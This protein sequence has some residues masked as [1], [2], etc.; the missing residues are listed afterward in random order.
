MLLSLHIKNFVLI[1]DL[2]IDFSPQLNIIT[3]E[4]GAGKSILLGALNLILG[5]RADT[6]VLKDNGKTCVIEGRFSLVNYDLKEIFFEEDIDYLEQSTIRREIRASGKSRVFVNDNQITLAGLKKIAY[7]IIDIHEQFD[8]HFLTKKDFQFDVIDSLAQ[9]KEEVNQ[10]R[11]RFQQLKEKENQLKAMKAKAIEEAQKKDFLEF[12]LNEIESLK[13]K[14]GEFKTLE[15]ELSFTKN[16]ELID[17]IVQQ[18]EHIF[19]TADESILDQMRSLLIKT[20]SASGVFEP[21]QQL[22]S[23]LESSLIEL[24]DIQSEYSSLKDELEIEPGRSEIIETRMGEIFRVMKK[25]YL[26]QSDDI[27][28]LAQRL[29]DELAEISQ[30]DAGI[31]KYQLEIEKDR[32]ELEKM[33]TTISKRRQSQKNKI[34]KSVLEKLIHLQ[35]DKSRFEIS[36]ETMDHLDEYGKDKIS[37]LFSANP[38]MALGSID[39]VASGGE[40]SRLALSIKALVAKSIPLPTIVF[41]E[42]DAGVSGAAADKM[43]SLLHELSRDH[44]VI[45]ITHSPQVASKA[46]RHLYVFKQVK[47]KETKTDIATLTLDQRVHQLAIMLSS[48]PPSAFAVENAKYLI[49]QVQ[50]N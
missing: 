33:A 16:I 22:E 36:L 12:Q 24:E 43:G 15:E 27:L 11:K 49:E 10:Y 32:K 47:Q 46:D 31:D 2:T 4:T 6:S 39:K 41:D 25:H 26:D 18:A 40:I 23:R 44:Q 50:S 8:N 42:I 7:K 35:L 37:Y 5:Q 1:D 28:S 3:G 13:Y 38:G 45:C 21:L 20:R 30:L 29:S 9:Q 17:E 34:Q 48:D 14:E 19:E